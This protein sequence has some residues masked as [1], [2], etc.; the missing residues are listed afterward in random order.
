MD[1]S[2]EVAHTD[3]L[4]VRGAQPFNAEPPASTLVE[5][6]YTPEDLIYCRNH[7]AFSPLSCG[8]FEHRP[9]SP[10][11]VEEYDE[12]NYLVT[13]DGLV[14]N[15]TKLSISTLRSNFGIVDVVAALQVRSRMIRFST[16]C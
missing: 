13:I 3:R 5:F 9:T 15:P 12:D 6:K 1:Y 4:I 8:Q 16:T 14:S 2:R 7:G 10:G 11:P